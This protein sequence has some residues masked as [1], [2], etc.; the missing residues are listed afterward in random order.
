[1]R[2]KERKEENS[3]AEGED[4]M[5]LGRVTIFKREREHVHFSG[6]EENIKERFLWVQEV[7][8]SVFSLR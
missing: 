4:A 6:S 1:L 2:R 8:G 7:V 5:G 3:W